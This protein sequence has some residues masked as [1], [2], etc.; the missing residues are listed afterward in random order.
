MQINYPFEAFYYSLFFL[1]FHN[2]NDS[3]YPE[4]GHK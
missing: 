2:R 1:I 3:N 4:N